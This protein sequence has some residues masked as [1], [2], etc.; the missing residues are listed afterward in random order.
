MNSKKEWF[1][2]ITISFIII[3]C[4]MLYLVLYFFNNME[5]LPEGELIG[6][7]ISPSNEYRVKTYLCRGSAT[8]ANA[9]RGELIVNGNIKNIYWGYREEEAIVEWADDDTVIINGNS[10]D[11]PNGVYDWR[12]K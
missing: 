2:G 1:F 7:S 3:V 5:R 11:L 8:V 4:I 10:I 9:I 12:R 6:E